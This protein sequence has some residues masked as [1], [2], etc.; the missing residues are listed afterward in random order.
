MGKLCIRSLA[1]MAARES[2]CKNANECRPEFAGLSVSSI[3]SRHANGI[4]RQGKRT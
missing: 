4:S 2:Y 1:I 3:F